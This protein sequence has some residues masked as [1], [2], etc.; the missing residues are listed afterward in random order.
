MSHLWTVDPVI[1][2]SG[3]LIG[4]L[5]G[6]T[7]MG[8]GALMTPLLVP[9]FGVVCFGYQIGWNVGSRLGPYPNR[10]SDHAATMSNSRRATPFNR[11]FNPGRLSRPLMPLMPSSRREIATT[12]QPSRP[13]ASWSGCSWFSTV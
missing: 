13:A 1:S 12:V 9:L 5:V 11:A 2:L 10:Q 3:F 6:Q 4:L 8:G 7:G